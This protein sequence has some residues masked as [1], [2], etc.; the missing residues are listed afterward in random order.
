MFHY[1]QAAINTVKNLFLQTVMNGCFFHF[2]QSVWR[3][4]QNTR[5]TIKYHENSNFFLHIKMLNALA[6]YYVP[7][8]LLLM[9]LK[10]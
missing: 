6:Y 8:N 4:I 3:N 2:F 9:H 1:E 7:Q 5:L 10:I